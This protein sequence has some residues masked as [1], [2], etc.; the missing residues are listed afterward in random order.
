MCILTVSHDKMFT[1]RH[2]RCKKH[3]NLPTGTPIFSRFE[4]DDSVALFASVILQTTS[5]KST[6]EYLNMCWKELLLGQCPSKSNHHLC[7]TH[8]MRMFMD[9][10]GKPQYGLTSV[11]PSP[12]KVLFQLYLEAQTIMEVIFYVKKMLFLLLSPSISSDL[13][14]LLAT[15]PQPMPSTFSAS[16]ETQII[17]IDFRS[18]SILI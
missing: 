4:S 15:Y 8:A 14:R 6:S 5:C 18:E 13:Q 12:L 10:L 16:M 17:F 2:F 11:D 3:C 1:I 7:R 9:K